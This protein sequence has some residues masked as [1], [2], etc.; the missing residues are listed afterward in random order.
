MLG[1]VQSGT[2]DAWAPKIEKEALGKQEG[3][4]SCGWLDLGNEQIDRRADPRFPHPAQPALDCAA[5]RCLPHLV[6]LLLTQETKFDANPPRP[7]RFSIGG[8]TA[9]RQSI[10]DI[11]IHPGFAVRKKR[12]EWCVAKRLLFV[13]PYRRRS[14]WTPSNGDPRRVS[15]RCG[16]RINDPL[17]TNGLLAYIMGA[18][19]PGTTD[20]VAEAGQHRSRAPREPVTDADLQEDLDA[21][22]LACP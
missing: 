17:A 11:L 19:D 21:S 4:S 3:L 20:C 6:A 16:G 22:R 14:Q 7:S 2:C 13:F 12:P 10:D 15:R 8:Y 18:I 1:Y 9:H 5:G